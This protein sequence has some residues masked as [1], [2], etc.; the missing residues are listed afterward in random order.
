VAVRRALTTRGVG[1]AGLVAR[2][3]VAQR[4]HP[5]HVEREQRQEDHQDG[6][7]HDVHYSTTGAPP[8]TKRL[9]APVA[10]RFDRHHPMTDA[11]R[12][13]TAR[14][15]SLWQKVAALAPVLLL[16]VYLPGQTMLR[17]R[18]DGQLRDACC[19]PQDDGQGDS[20]GPVLR[21][22]DCCDRQDTHTARPPAETV[23]GPSHD[24]ATV[25]SLVVAMAPLPPLT[26]PRERFGRTAQRHGPA[27]DGPPIVLLK[28]AFLI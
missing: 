6:T 14:R 16:L 12:G 17:C 27:H 1:R 20:S 10:P 26:S 18:L 7:P 9:P 2:P 3:L 5:A 25:A 19:C 15:F 28:H 13:M 11:F 24:S 4:P 8:M 23:R 21:A 22:Q